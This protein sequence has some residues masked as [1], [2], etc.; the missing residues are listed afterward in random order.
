MAVRFPAALLIATMSL[1]A[2]SQQPDDSVAT[3]AEPV[4]AEVTATPPPPAAAPT[5]G[6]QLADGFAPVAFDLAGTGWL[7]V[8]ID[9]K[10]LGEAWSDPVRIYFGQSSLHWGGCNSHESLYVRS[11]SSFATGGSS[12]STLVACPPG[13][14][15]PIVGGVL[16]GQPLIGSNAEGKIMLATRAHSVTL[17]Q[18]DPPRADPA[19]P[20]LSRAP[21]RLTVEDGGSQPP[22]IA[23]GSGT[24][25][26]WMDCPDAITG[27]AVVRDGRLITGDVSQK[28]CDTHRPTATA[29]LAAFFRHGPAIAQGPN[30]ELLLSDGEEVI[31]GRQCHPDTSP[32]R[33]AA[34]N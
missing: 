30:G 32:C 8:A 23:F 1:A 11:G 22:V 6:P 17:S 31:G 26:I 3:P 7:V 2:C 18:I 21:F 12:V 13:A 29:A 25:S 27:K 20:P 14:P 34:A 19:P 28:T 15:D 5:S 33:H 24:L 10:P 9:G 4:D 16:H